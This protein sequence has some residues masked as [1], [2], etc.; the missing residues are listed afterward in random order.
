MSSGN[1]QAVERQSPVSEAQ[2]SRAI[3]IV[4]ANVDRLTSYKL[5]SI[6][7]YALTVNTNVLA[8]QE[9]TQL[10]GIVRRRKLK[11]KLSD[12]KIQQLVNKYT[13]TSCSRNFSSKDAFVGHKAQCPGPGTALVRSRKGTTAVAAAERNFLCNNCLIEEELE[14]NLGTIKGVRAFRYLGV[15][16]TATAKT[17]KAYILKAGDI[18]IL[19]ILKEQQ[20]SW[21]ETCATAEMDIELTESSRKLETYLF[22][23]T[24]TPAENLN[25]PPE[26]IRKELEHHEHCPPFTRHHPGRTAQPHHKQHLSS[27]LDTTPTCISNNFWPQLVLGW[28]TGEDST[29]SLHKPHLSFKTEL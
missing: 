5:R 23:Q 2:D 28:I 18:N 17:H 9:K 13:C 7:E 4:S 8:I 29:G 19:E 26:H 3:S 22:P 6:E 1:T 21:L 20:K 24:P 12:T 14:T 15:D 16:V 11:D 27:S 10:M 25:V